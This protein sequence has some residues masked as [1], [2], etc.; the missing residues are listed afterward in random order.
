MCMLLSVKYFFGVVVFHT[1]MIN[2][3]GGTSAL[4]IGALCSM[5]NIFSVVVF[6][7]SIVNWSGGSTSALSICAFCYM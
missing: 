3:K 1:C 2:W 6:H 5:L 7:A 4:N